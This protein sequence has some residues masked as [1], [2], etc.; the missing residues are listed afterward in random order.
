M[1]MVME[2]ALSNCLETI[3]NQD[4]TLEDCAANYPEHEKELIDLLRLVYA[5]KELD[6]ISPR[7][8]FVENAS[9]HLVSKLP[10]RNV[11]YH[12]QIR[13]IR[14]K[15]Q[16]RLNLSRR[17][18]LFQVAM[19]LVF[20][21]VALTGGSAYA[22]NSAVPGDFFYEVDLAFERLHLNFALNNEI[23]ARIHL[24][25]ADERLLEAGKVLQYGDVRNGNTALVGYENEIAAAAKMVGSKTGVGRD[26]LLLLLETALS[27][28]KYV[29]KD[30][31]NKHPEQCWSG[32]QRALI[33]SSKTKTEKSM[34]PPVDITTGKPEDNNKGKS[35]DK[36]KGKPDHIGTPSGKP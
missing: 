19:V 17:F 22:A 36:I 5:L 27:R 32:I 8:V 4:S 30:L 1:T 16:V 35:K 6:Q 18:S 20:V 10:D 29:L 34:E 7:A 11:A 31:I 2:D 3:F 15:Q 23:A 25:I 26:K 24:R 13:P 9:Q 21:L 12:K 28:H 33:A 14:R